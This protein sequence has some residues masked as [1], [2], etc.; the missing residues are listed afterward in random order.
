YQETNANAIKA[1]GAHITPFIEKATAIGIPVVAH[2]GLTPQSVGV[3]G[4]K[5]QGATKEAAEQLILDAKNV[6]QAGA[7]AL[8]LEAI[9][10][11]LAEEISKHLT[12]PVIGIGAGKG[13]DGQVLVYHD[14]LNYGVEHKAKFVK[15]FADFSVGVDGLKQYDQEVKSGAFPSEEY[16]YKKKIMNEVNNND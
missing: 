10:N 9:P 6:E 8:V 4:Y 2:L 5:L 11:D 7:V 12:I 3:M 13:T 15:Q 14:M 1:E 16:T